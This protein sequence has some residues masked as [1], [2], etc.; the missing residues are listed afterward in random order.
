MT[1]GTVLY[2]D[3]SYMYYK[4]LFRYDYLVVLDKS[5]IFRALTECLTT[6]V[7]VVLSDD[8]LLIPTDPT[9]TTTL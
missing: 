3:L 5:N 8:A 6:H 4:V 1:D 7:Y 2:R 9:T